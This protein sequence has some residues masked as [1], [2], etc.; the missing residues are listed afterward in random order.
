TD[1]R[2]LGR[3]AGRIDWTPPLGSDGNV[4]IAAHRDTA[5][6]VLRKVS[7]GDEVLVDWRGGTLRYEVVETQ[8][9]EPTDVHVLDPTAEPRV[10]LVTC[11]PFDF[12]GAAPLRFIVVAELSDDGPAAR[13]RS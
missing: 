3:G 12:V 5:F 7:I 2:S 6:A 11:Y 9:V 8:I 10:T 1:E 13:A 4:G